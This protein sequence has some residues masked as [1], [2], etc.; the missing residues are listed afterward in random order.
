M[1]VTL[2]SLPITMYTDVELHVLNAKMG[3]PHRAHAYSS[4][5]TQSHDNEY[6]YIYHISGEKGKTMW[7]RSP[8]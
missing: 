3:S 6:I 2:I 1:H 8:T 7:V 4:Y 5:I